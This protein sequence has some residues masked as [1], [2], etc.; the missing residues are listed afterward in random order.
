MTPVLDYKFVTAILVE[1]AGW[2]GVADGS[3]KSDQ[4]GLWFIDSSLMAT[5]WT[6][7]QYNAI[8]GYR[9]KKNA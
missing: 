5:M 8:L 4:G 9:M 2:I 7:V 6:F 3:M 1:S